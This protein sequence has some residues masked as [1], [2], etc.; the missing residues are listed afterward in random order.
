LTALSDWVTIPQAYKQSDADVG[1]EGVLIESCGPGEPIVRPTIPAVVLTNTP[2]ATPER[3]PENGATSTPTRV[4]DTATPTRAHTPTLTGTPTKE[5]TATPVPGP[6]NTPVITPSPV[7]T[8]THEIPT[9][10][11]P[12]EPTEEHT[13]TPPGT[14]T[15]EATAEATATPV[16]GPTEEPTEEPATPVPTNTHTIPTATAPATATPPDSYGEGGDLYFTNS[17]GSGESYDPN[18]VPVN[19]PKPVGG[20]G[21]TVT[22]V[23]VGGLLVANAGLVAVNMARARGREAWRGIK[24]RLGMT[25]RA[26]PES[27]EGVENSQNKHLTL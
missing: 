21:D 2:G 17:D 15:K 24:D 18:P 8:N 19:E 1:H 20:A 16:P 14:P 12:A 7:A 25:K 9:A 5:A 23:V 6:T 22:G 26:E 27:A 13:P 11:P 3:T 10:T 4:P